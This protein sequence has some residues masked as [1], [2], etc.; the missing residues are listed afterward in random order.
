[1][2]PARKTRVKVRAGPQTLG[3]GKT[4]GAEDKS[5]GVS[6]GVTLTRSESV[7]NVVNRGTGRTATEA[8]EHPTGVGAMA[9][10]RSL[11]LSAHKLLHKHRQKKIQARF[12][13]KKP[14]V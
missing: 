13:H 3:I 6:T 10:V 12:K 1:M 4:D 8:S 2:G 11:I 9:G 7:E 14:N 5:I